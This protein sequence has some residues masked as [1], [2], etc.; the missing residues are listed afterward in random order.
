MRVQLQMKIIPISEPIS[1]PEAAIMLSKLRAR[2]LKVMA[3]GKTVRVMDTLEHAKEIGAISFD[4]VV[5][6]QTARVGGLLLVFART[7]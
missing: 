1:D 5:D 2:G 6:D 7:K 3:H 4:E